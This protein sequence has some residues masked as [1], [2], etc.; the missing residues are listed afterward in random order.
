MPSP[1]DEAGHTN[2]FDYL[3]AEHWGE[4]RNVQFRGW[5][6]TNDDILL[7]DPSHTTSAE[8]SQS[9]A[10]HFQLL[11]PFTAIPQAPVPLPPLGA[12]SDSP[13]KLYHPV[14]L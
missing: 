9:A 2:A 1:I 8:S 12:S 14:A 13:S 11:N 3:V 6:C 10:R 5:D 7:S 4:S